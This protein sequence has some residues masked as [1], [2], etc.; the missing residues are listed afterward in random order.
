MSAATWRIYLFGKLQ[1]QGAQ[2]T[3]N[4]LSMRR[5][6]ALL[7]GLLLRHPN[8]MPREELLGIL[9]PDEDLSV[10]R[11]R[12]RVLLNALRQHLEPGDAI[13]GSVLQAERSAIQL[14]VG[15]F[16]SDYH[17]F[18]Q[19]LQTAKDAVS[20]GD[21]V[22]ALKQAVALYR[23]ELLAGFYDE[24]IL[25]ERRR[26]TELHY[27]ALRELTRRLMQSDDPEQAVDYARQAVVAEPLDEEAHEDL[28]RLYQ[29]IGQPAAALRQYDQLERLLREEVAAE[30]SADSRRLREQI[31]SGLG[32]GITQAVRSVR[33]ALPRAA[34]QKVDRRRSTHSLPH[35]LTRFFGRDEEIIQLCT[36]LAPD[37]PTRLVT[38][39][40]PGGTGKTRLAVEAAERLLDV[41]GGRVY[42][43]P[44]AE[45]VSPQQIG[46]ALGR[47]LR[48]PN[49]PGMDPLSQALTVL[50]Q[51]P[52]LLV[53]DNLEQLMPEA[54]PLIEHLLLEAT[55]L[56]CLLTSRL[57][58]G[59]EGEQEIVLGPLPQPEV[60]MDL[61]ALSA[62]PGVALF[63]DRVR[64]V[65]SDFTVTAN[66]ADDVAQLCRLLEGLPLAIE[67]AAA[68]ARVMTPAEMRAQTGGL[69]SWLVDTRGG[70]NARHRSVRATL[71]WSFRL[72]PPLERRFFT[73]VSVFAGGF[74]VE[75]AAF[76]ALGEGMPGEAAIGLLERL[77]AASLLTTS[78]TEEAKT[79][80]GQLE[81]VREFGRE[82][83]IESDTASDVKGRH[84]R[85]FAQTFWEDNDLSFHQEGGEMTR[86]AADDSNMRQALEFGMRSEAEENEQRLAL[87][88]AVKLT[89]YWEMQGRWS[90]GRVSLRR[91]SLLA[92]AG[93][94]P[95]L[96]IAALRGAGALANL[97][98]D[99][100]E[101]RSLSE[102]GLALAQTAGYAAG[103]AGCLKNLGGEAF[104]RDD[105]AGAQS[106]Y[107]QALRVYRE[108]GD[109]KNMG[110]CLVSLGNVAFFLGVYAEAQERL[111]EALHLYEERDD[112]QGIASVLIRMGNV[113]RDQTHNIEARGYLEEARRIFQ[114][115]GSRYNV[116]LCVHDLAMVAYN[117][118][119]YAEAHSRFMQAQEMFEA[120]GYGRGVRSCLFYRGIISQ[121]RG[122]LDEA[123][124]LFKQAIERCRKEGDRR[125]L[126]SSLVRLGAVALRQGDIAEAHKRF[127]EALTIEQEIGS[128]GG[129]ANSRYALGCLA[130]GQD[131]IDE[132]RRCLSEALTIYYSMGIQ[133]GVIETL[134]VHALLALRC[135]LAERAAMLMGAVGR[136]R[137]EVQSIRAPLYLDSDAVRDAIRT[138]LGSAEY[139]RVSARGQSLSTADA[140]AEALKET[141]EE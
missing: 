137:Q 121:D 120:I 78:E 43:V 68:R 131:D 109:T 29:A 102:E 67:L 129:I 41:Y 122:D 5:L 124:S 69:L 55:S 13:S 125:N 89:D 50:G 47:A 86:F 61:Q 136:M 91:A 23:G 11:N 128:R 115:G 64:S 65:R 4:Q 66:N 140:V 60:G 112:R 106:L 49:T 127:Q 93:T 100:T 2:K 28:M 76:V 104:Y 52:A 30:P 77:R 46:F 101:A 53:L 54:A 16:T 9:W 10:S 14:A 36:L 111:Q 34:E 81:T 97:M 51:S 3:L 1:V 98:G 135:K 33:P 141:S 126:A 7:A 32:H 8:P 70:K 85:Y 74:T 80:F 95:L 59:I 45:A 108:E 25:A 105:Y 87:Q 123:L 24:W 39:L 18:L 84:F 134:E 26:I 79:R 38:L 19:A 83:L 73:A 31:E 96:R 21:K 17:D 119:E 56:R 63:V 116:A 99:Y 20:E 71:E 130:L 114:E 37:A 15:A 75:A 117:Q 132:A 138:A 82:R 58:A 62:C 133:A 107:E 103:V 12:L 35:R 92:V 44:L 6:G 40:G 27:M 110:A 48:L 113:R 118:S 139:A 72:L 22:A 42:F 90:D 57:I 94:E 88:L